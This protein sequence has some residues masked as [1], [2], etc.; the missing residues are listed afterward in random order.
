LAGLSGRA[1]D[2]LDALR[3][4]CAELNADGSRGRFTEAET[5]RGGQPVSGNVGGGG[6]APVEAVCPD[7]VPFVRQ[8]GALPER[9][10][11]GKLFIQCGPMAG[12]IPPVEQNS[13][14][15]TFGE[16]GSETLVPTYRPMTCPSGAAYAGIHG[17]AGEWIDAIGNICRRIEPVPPPP[18]LSRD[19]PIVTSS[20]TAAAQPTGPNPIASVQLQ[21]GVNA[22]ATTARAGLEP[23]QLLCRGG[24]VYPTGRQGQVPDKPEQEYH[25]VFV[26]ISQNIA[27]P[28]GSGLSPG[29]CGFADRVAT[30]VPTFLLPVDVGSSTLADLETYLKHDPNHFWSFLLRPNQA[31]KMPEAIKHEQWA[32]PAQASAA[33]TTSPIQDTAT[34]ASSAARQRASA[35]RERFPVDLYQVNEAAMIA[36]GA[37][38]MTVRD[39]RLEV[40][41][42][43]DRLAEPTRAFALCVIAGKDCESAAAANGRQSAPPSSAPQPAG[44]GVAP[45]LP[46]FLYGLR[47]GSPA[48]LTSQHSGGAVG[49]A[50]TWTLTQ[51]LPRQFGDYRL[52][53]GAGREALYGVTTGDTL[54]YWNAAELGDTLRDPSI[55]VT[56][57]APSAYAQI[58]AAQG[59][60]YGFR[61]DGTVDVF[62]NPSLDAGGR[63]WQAP[64]RVADDWPSF[65]RVISG[66]DNV[67]YTVQPDGSLVWRR[68]YPGNNGWSQSVPVGT[69]WGQYRDLFTPGEGVI[70][71]IQPNGELLWHRFRGHADGAAASGWEGPVKIADGWQSFKSVV[72]TPAR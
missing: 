9:K 59:V 44:S 45:R 35:V 65:D 24:D 61:R 41:A 18:T 42:A 63:T 34:S 33:L 12:P 40:E 50:G 14:T 1:G 31:L 23:S 37:R 56:G 66:G 69:A 17:R 22:P 60:V 10:L 48:L 47:E 16:V 71:A 3:P 15:F 27:R 11:V 72:A 62:R 53:I 2:D 7:A 38:Q 43:L 68:H 29:T 55:L 67:F 13:N 4:V 64:Q 26:R 39:A 36:V 46:A 20:V 28:D 8:M 57:F 51:E 25:V 54:R 52:L 49:D 21:Q 19:A 70:Y 6:G 32:A 58:A 5:V 30:D